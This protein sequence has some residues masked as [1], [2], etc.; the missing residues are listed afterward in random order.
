MSNM[1]RRQFVAAGAMGLAATTGVQSSVPKPTSSISPPP[2]ARF[3]RPVSFQAFSLVKLEIDSTGFR[4]ER[5]FPEDLS[6]TL[7][8]VHALGYAGIELCSPIGYGMIG[9]GSLR[10]VPPG[11]IKRR[12]EDAGLFCKSCH[13][14]PVELLGGEPERTADYANALGLSDVIL[15]ISGLAGERGEGSSDQF[16]AWGENM[17]KVG[18]V[19]KAAGLRLGYH[20]HSVGPEVEGKPQYDWIMESIDPEL[21]TMQFQIASIGD[22]YDVLYYLEKYA[23]RISSLHMVDWDPAMKSTREGRLGGPVP[24]GA[25]MIDW[26]DLL[27]LAIKDGV[28]EHGFIVEIETG[29]QFDGLSKSIAYLQSVEL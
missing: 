27:K 15:S 28:A 16:K 22:G 26:S 1:T 6:G 10:D 24:C 12:I 23:G 2:R 19:M 4:L 20:N 5:P 25:G 18:E 21:V 9:F 3:D 13:F 11:E 17:N 8:A 14:T 7:D 29:E